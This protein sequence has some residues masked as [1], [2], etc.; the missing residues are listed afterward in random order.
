MRERSIGSSWRRAISSTASSTAES[1]PSPSRSIFRKPASAQES[2]SHWQIWRPAIAA[3]CTGT[4]SISG[5]VEITIP[6]GCWERWRG[7]PAIS[8]VSSRKASQRGPACVARARRASSLGDAGRVPAVGDAGEPLELGEREAERLADVA[9]RAA[10]PVGREGG[11]ERGVL[12]AVALGDGDD[13]LLAD[14]AREVEVDVGHRRRARRSGSG[15]A[16]GSPRPGRR[17]RGRSGSRRSS[18]RSSLSPAPAAATFRGEPAPR[19]SS[20]QSRA[21]SSTSQWSR[22]KPARPSR[23]ISAQLGL[24]AVV[25]ALLVRRSRSA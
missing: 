25:R 14:V 13:Q 22:K 8:C 15:R 4:R 9:D 7:R 1:I 12:A 17:G 5:R 24:E 20:A 2:L 18:R 6:P 3:G 19:T 11:D 23:A 10:A 16:R 21:S